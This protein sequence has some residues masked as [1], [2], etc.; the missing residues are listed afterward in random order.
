[1]SVAVTCFYQKFYFTKTTVETLLNQVRLSSSE[2]TYK[3]FEK[4]CFI[5]ITVSGYVLIDYRTVSIYIGLFSTSLHP[6]SPVIDIGA[7]I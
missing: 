6:S 2:G 1:M 5:Y 4:N 7:Q 3:T